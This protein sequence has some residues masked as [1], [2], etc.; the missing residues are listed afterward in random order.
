MV[1]DV[2]I[3]K[4]FRA[5]KRKPRKYSAMYLKGPI[6]CQFHKKKIKLGEN[7]KKKQVMR[8]MH[9]HSFHPVTPGPGCSKLTTSLVNVSL[10]F[11]LLIPHI[12]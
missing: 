12:C 1:L 10:K 2:P 3:L 11:Q 4:H 6:N 5:C 7:R 9:C 8:E